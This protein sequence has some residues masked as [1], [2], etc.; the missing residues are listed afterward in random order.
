MHTGLCLLLMSDRECVS[1]LQWALPRMGFRWPGYRKV[2]GQVCKRIRRR[3]HEL[4]LG[5]LRAYQQ[6]L[7]G[8]A[9]EWQ[10]LDGLCRITISRFCRDREVFRTLTTEVLP[11]LAR[12]ARADNLAAVEIWSAGCGAG[13]EPYSLTVL[14]EE[15]DDP[16][17]SQISLHIIATDSDG[18]QIERARTATYPASCLRELSPASRRRAF[19]RVELNSFRL[20]ERYRTGVELRRQDLR[21]DMPEGPFHLILCRNLAFTYFDTGHQREI[22]AGLTGNLAAGSYLVIGTHERLPP[23]LHSLSPSPH[24]PCILGPLSPRTAERD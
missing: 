14:A 21:R 23:T 10:T 18:Y 16:V 17:L 19:E 13:E 6:Y 11:R 1:F 24:C 22:L 4:G 7:A 15:H 8:H 5:N 2:R 20:R 9:D 12:Q 3:L